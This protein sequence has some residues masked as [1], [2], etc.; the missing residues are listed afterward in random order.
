[1]CFEDA[2]YDPADARFAFTADDEIVAWAWPACFGEGGSATRVTLDNDVRPSWRGRGIGAELLAW[3]AHRGGVVVDRRAPP[4]QAGWLEVKAYEQQT[5]RIELFERQ[6]FGELRHFD[7]LERDLAARIDDVVLPARTRLVG[8]E[9]AYDEATRRTHNAAFADHWGHRDRTP[10]EWRVH[11][12]GLPDFRSD[13]SRLVLD[14]EDNV[15]GYALVGVHPHE[16]ETLGRTE[17]WIETLGVVRAWRG[18][19]SAT[20]MLNATMR[21]I[22]RAGLQF[23]ALGVDSA[24]LTGANRVYEAV[25]FRRFSRWT[26]FAKPLDGRPGPTFPGPVPRDRG[27]VTGSP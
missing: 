15:I 16:F 18:R 10:D 26:V 27:L 24:S 2:G 5:D 7:E 25:G 9:R 3:S 4:G 13:L 1:M 20:A 21:A 8:F 11:M 12:T 23:A 14:D 6:G 19:G 17:A 22:R